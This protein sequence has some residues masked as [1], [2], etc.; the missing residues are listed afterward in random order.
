MKSAHAYSAE[1]CA[2]EK[3]CDCGWSDMATE[4]SPE[5]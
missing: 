3:R 4:R 1:S 2:N 5:L